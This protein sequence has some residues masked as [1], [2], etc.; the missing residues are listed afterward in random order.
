M[1][2]V[3]GNGTLTTCVI[4]SWKILCHSA[5]VCRKDEGEAGGDTYAEDA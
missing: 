4:K 3:V 1:C 2:S 5:L